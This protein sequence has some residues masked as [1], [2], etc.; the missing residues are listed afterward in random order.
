VPQRL[1]ERSQLVVP[2]VGIGCVGVLLLVGAIN[3]LWVM[4]GLQRHLNG[5][6]AIIF[7]EKIT[8]SSQLRG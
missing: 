3:N 2:C 7:G 6:D 1:K 8:G 5:D 4:K